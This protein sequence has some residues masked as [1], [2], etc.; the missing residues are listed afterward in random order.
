[1]RDDGDD[2]SLTA[3]PR[4]PSSSR[5]R[6]TAL[7]IG[8]G[9][10]GERLQVALRPRQARTTRSRAPPPPVAAPPRPRSPGRPGARP[11]RETTPPRPTC[12]A[13]P[14]LRLGPGPGSRSAAAARPRTA[15]RTLATEMKETRSRSGPGR[16]GA[17]RARAPGRWL[18]SRNGL[19][20][21]I[22]CAG[23]SASSPLYA[24]CVEAPTTCAAPRWRKGNQ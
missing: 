23:A 24:I 12:S 8:L 19:T 3:R 16:T 4:G 2:G 9:E 13:R 5:V 22:P 20:L 14:E 6:D 21:R 10:P 7:A 17:R 1:M 18:R 15:G 11:G